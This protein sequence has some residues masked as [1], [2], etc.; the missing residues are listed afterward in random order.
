MQQDHVLAYP[1]REALAVSGMTRS[2]VYIALG[3]GEL[4]ARK[5]GRR[6]LIDAQSL[7]QHI[8]NLPVAT[9]RAPRAA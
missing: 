3:K 6:L 2:A 1:L 4:V 5:S 9:I 8:A 7:R